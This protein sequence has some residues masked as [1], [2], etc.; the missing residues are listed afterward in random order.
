MGCEV[1]PY[2]VCA[3]PRSGSAWLANFLTSGDCLCI[4]EPIFSAPKAEGYRVV[5]GVDTGAAYFLA[6]IREQM[7]AVRLYALVRNE[8]DAKAS[9]EALG[10]TWLDWPRPDVPTFHHEK[11][12]DPAYLREVWAELNGPGFDEIRARQLIG[13]NVQRDL[14]RLGETAW[15]G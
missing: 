4:H 15:R 14:A 6:Q 12:F 9:A 2:L 5:G 13:M 10:L 1:T 7:P 8:T 11:L 3:M